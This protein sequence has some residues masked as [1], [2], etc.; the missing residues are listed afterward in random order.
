M[1]FS[2]T[3]NLETLGLEE[4]NL[5]CQNK[6]HWSKENGELEFGNV[7]FGMPLG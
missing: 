5:R 6:S 1:D 2:G 4:G 7:E 3:E